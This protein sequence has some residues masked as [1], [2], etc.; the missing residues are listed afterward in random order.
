MEL[1]RGS[2]ECSAGGS[3]S[4]ETL[5]TV[6]IRLFLLSRTHNTSCVQLTEHQPVFFPFPTV[7]AE[8]YSTEWLCQLQAPTQCSCP[9]LTC[10]SCCWPLGFGD[11]GDPSGAEVVFLLL[12][13]VSI[14]HPTALGNHGN[15][16]RFGTSPGTGNTPHTSTD[17]SSCH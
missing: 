17:L 2:Q 4:R 13:G 16:T 14:T 6:S 10:Q 11:P 1:C 15:T 12:T 7:A 9:G 8:L 5:Q 3:T